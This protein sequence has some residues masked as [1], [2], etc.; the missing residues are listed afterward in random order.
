METAPH[1]SDGP[2][3]EADRL[4]RADDEPASREDSSAGIDCEVRGFIDDLKLRRTD[5]PPT[6]ER[7]RP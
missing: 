7:P 1:D 2:L 4:V 3:E 6:D 5:A